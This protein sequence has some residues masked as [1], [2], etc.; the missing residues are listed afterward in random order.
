MTRSEL[1]NNI[2]NNGYQL[3]DKIFD[4]NMIQDKMCNGLAKTILNANI[5]KYDTMLDM[6]TDE[7]GHIN[8]D[9]IINMIPENISM[10]LEEYAN[11]FDIPKWMLPNKIIFIT[12]EDI[13]QIIKG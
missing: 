2:K 10:D 4:T 9:E 5:N 8:V 12:R 13:I 11:R 6:I 7:S 1:K 3:I